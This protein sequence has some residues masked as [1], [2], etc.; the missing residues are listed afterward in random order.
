MTRE[1]PLHILIVD[2]WPEHRRALER[3]LLIGF[4]RRLDFTEAATGEAALEL[5]CLRAGPR[6]D[7]MLLDVNLPDL[8]AFE[9]LEELA[10]RHGR[11]DFPVVTLTSAADDQKA[12]AALEAGAQDFLDKSH[13]NAELLARVV[14]NSMDRFRLLEKV[15][16]SEERFRRFLANMSHEIRTPMTAILGYADLLNARLE[17]PKDLRYI[18]TIK[19]NGEYLIE[20]IN[21]I[22]DLSKIEAGRLEI[23][24][25]QFSLPELVEDVVSLMQVRAEESAVP[26]HVEYD[27]LVPETIETDPVRVRQ[28]LVNLLGNAIKFTEDGEVRLRVGT[29]SDRLDRIVFEVTDTGIGMTQDQVDRLF[30]PFQQGDASVTRRFG[31]TGLGLA[32]SKRLVDRLGGDIEVESEFGRGS[33]FRF[34]ID[35]GPV[36]KTSFVNPAPRPPV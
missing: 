36:A 11:V 35:S 4:E 10:D 31:G 25:Q 33:T 24:P 8:S 18:G 34:W 28:V 19:R 5:D 27:G 26:L 2:D 13:V 14:R 29:A 6:P 9:V 7:V 21:D 3:E 16:A 20:I 22:L 23:D 12:S 32:I 17:D 30:E 15:H 1:S